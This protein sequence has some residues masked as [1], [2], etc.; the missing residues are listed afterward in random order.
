MATMFAARGKLNAL[1]RHRPPDDPA[2]RA[3][4]ID[5]RVAKLADEIIREAEADPPLTVEQRSRL[6]A[7][8]TTP[9]QVGGGDAAA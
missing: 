1:Q 7:L 5:L 6:A 3:A 9:H 2:I 4:R 8:L